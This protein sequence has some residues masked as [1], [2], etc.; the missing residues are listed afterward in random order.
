MIPMDRQL[1]E[2]L[3]MEGL[4]VYPGC[5]G[6]AIQPVLEKNEDDDGDNNERNNND[7]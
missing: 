2:P 1:S 5:W 6:A 3:Q 4:F 7:I